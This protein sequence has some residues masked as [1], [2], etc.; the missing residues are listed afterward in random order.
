MEAV[1]QQA[2]VRCRTEDKKA[3]RRGLRVE[4]TPAIIRD[5]IA[6]TSLGVTPAPPRMRVSR[7][8]SLVAFAD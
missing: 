5:G 6:A 4:Q 1:N 8:I 7:K 3:L 2:V